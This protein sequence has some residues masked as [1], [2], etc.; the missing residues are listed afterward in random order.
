[1]AKNVNKID[2]V[3]RNDELRYFLGNM[4]TKNC[5]VVKMHSI[6]LSNAMTETMPLASRFRESMV[7]ENRCC[8][9]GIITPEHFR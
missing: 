2:D 6:S 7:G 3:S 1:M 8:T 5:G 4:L 9:S